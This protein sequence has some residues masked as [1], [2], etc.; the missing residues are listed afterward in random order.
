MRVL[1]N[2]PEALWYRCEAGMPRVASPVSAP[3][4][5]QLGSIPALSAPRCLFK[6]VQG[7]RSCIG[8]GLDLFGMVGGLRGVVG[9]IMKPPKARPTLSASR[10]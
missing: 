1:R 5:S 6:R 2:R 3:I 10:P 4:G 8:Y 7:G 9:P